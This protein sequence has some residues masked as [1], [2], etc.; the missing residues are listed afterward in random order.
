MKELD[1][2]LV[3]CYNYLGNVMNKIEKFI[4]G[5]LNGNYIEIDAVLNN[6]KIDLK[7]FMSCV[8]NYFNVI[9]YYPEVK[10]INIYE[11]K[12]KDLI[13]ILED[14]KQSNI[15][16]VVLDSKLKKRLSLCDNIQIHQELQKYMQNRLTNVEV[17]K[18]IKNLIDKKD[19]YIYTEY[20]NYSKEDCLNEIKNL[21]SIFNILDKISFKKDI[22]GIKYKS[23]Y[24]K[25]G[26][27]EYESLGP[28]LYFDIYTIS[29]YKRVYYLI[30]KIIITKE[31]NKN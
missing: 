5:I 9:K 21:E 7:C 28:S 18:Y 6:K 23:V 29:Y 26:S 10:K 14:Y 16:C 27:I 8:V 31:T 2:Y 30:S 22:M 13:K 1:N 19:L 15:V 20:Y 17:I 24:F 4:N 25:P 11:N 12:Y 3:L